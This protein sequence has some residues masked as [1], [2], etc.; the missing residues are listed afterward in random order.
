MVDGVKIHNGH[1]TEE[2]YKALNA[3]QKRFL[4]R[5]RGGVSDNEV[6]PTEGMF[7]EDASQHCIN[8]GSN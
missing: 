8:Q 1:Y 7:K 6:P 3:N 2:E 4:Y 5:L